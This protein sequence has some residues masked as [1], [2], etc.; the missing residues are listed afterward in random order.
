MCWS[1]LMEIWE[2]ITFWS[3]VW[4]K[5]KPRWAR[6]FSLDSFISRVLEETW[7]FQK[8]LCFPRKIR[9]FQKGTAI[10]YLVLWTCQHY[11][12]EKQMV[13]SKKTELWTLEHFQ[14]K[15]FCQ[16]I[17]NIYYCL[18]NYNKNTMKFNETHSF[19]IYNNARLL[20]PIK[21]MFFQGVALCENLFSHK[22]LNSSFTWT[23]SVSK[24]INRNKC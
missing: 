1:V 21:H 11:L 6:F 13:Q 2:F 14:T 20:V 19:P 23:A 4:N 5:W 17:F 3:S 12:T 22:R 10:G 15:I 8:A 16:R 24:C 18:S 9:R 7:K